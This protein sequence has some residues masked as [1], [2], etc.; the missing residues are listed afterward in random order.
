MKTVTLREYITEVLKNAVYE[1]GESSN[2]IIAESPDLPGCFTQ[3]K[4]F[5]DARENLIDAIEL[6]ITVGL[7]KGEEMPL[8]NGCRLAA[9]RDTL[10]KKKVY[11]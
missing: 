3:G 10:K 5:E 6:W 1:K 8:V 4:N 11:V 9:D 7:R 2:V